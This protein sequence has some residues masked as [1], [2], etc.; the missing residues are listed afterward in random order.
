MK[1]AEGWVHHLSVATGNSVHSDKSISEG[2]IFSR[3][4]IS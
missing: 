1:D 4:Q 3:M 2:F